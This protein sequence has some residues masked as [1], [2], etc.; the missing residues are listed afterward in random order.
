MMMMRKMMVKVMRMEI[1]MRMAMERAMGREMDMLIF[2][3]KAKERANAIR[4]KEL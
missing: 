1:T 3:Q 4:K 2:T